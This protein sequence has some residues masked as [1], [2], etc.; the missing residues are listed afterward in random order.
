MHSEKVTNRAD[1]SSSEQNDRKIKRRTIRLKQSKD[2]V[3]DDQTE[4]G[5][6][7]L[8]KSWMQTYDPTLAEF[9]E[10]RDKN[11]KTANDSDSE[12]SYPG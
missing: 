9:M 12:K 4:S 3:I 8:K 10:L 11:C 7:S 2:Q 5:L 1:L 6:N